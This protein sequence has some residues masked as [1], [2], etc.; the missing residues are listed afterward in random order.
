[1][2]YCAEHGRSYLAPTI[3]YYCAVV[4]VRAVGT[5]GWYECVKMKEKS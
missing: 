1:M 2:Y 5:M 3:V 4:L